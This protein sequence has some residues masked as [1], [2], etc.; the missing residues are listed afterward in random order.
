MN[1][2]AQQQSIS[3]YAADAPRVAS[4]AMYDLEGLQEANDAL[5]AA[6]ARQLEDSGVVGAPTALARGGSLEAVWTDPQ[7]LLGQTCGYPLIGALKSHHVR[8]VATPRYRAPGCDGPFHRSVI[9]VRADS[10]V[11]SLAELRGARC[12]ANGPASNTGMNLL[13][14]EVAPLARDGVFFGSIAFTGSHE[15]SAERIAA[16]EADVAAID[17]IT[18][19]HLQRLRPALTRRLK[20]LGWSV[21]SPGLPLITGRNTDPVT[22]EALRSVLDAVEHDPAL[23]DVRAELLLDGFNALPAAQYRAIAH[24]EQIAAAQGYPTLA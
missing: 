19:A 6:I 8:L 17:C 13:R 7:L 2:W 23:R 21:R 4:L 20:V 9:V 18:W 16:A 11:A 14:V 5:W 15:A 3:A 12:A 1:A 24:L 22:Y 10:A